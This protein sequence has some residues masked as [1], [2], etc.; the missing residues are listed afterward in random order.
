MLVFGDLISCILFIVVIESCASK[1]SCFLSIDSPDE[2]CE[3]SVVVAN[4]NKDI[5]FS[6]EFRELSVVA[7]NEDDDSSVE[8]CELPIDDWDEDTDSFSQSRGTAICGTFA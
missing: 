5:D 7:G 3:L 6:V 1:M 8:F 4:E 2:F